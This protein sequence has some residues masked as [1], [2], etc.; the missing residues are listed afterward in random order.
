MSRWSRYTAVDSIFSVFGDGTRLIAVLAGA[1]YID[2]QF[3]LA[4]FIVFP[5]AV[6]P[7]IRFSKGMRKMTKDAQTPD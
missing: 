3:A 7:V 4:A 5:A 2:W 1:F 6:L